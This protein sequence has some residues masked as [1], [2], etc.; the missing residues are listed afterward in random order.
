MNIVI[1]DKNTANAHRRT[2]CTHIPAIGSSY[3]SA[4]YMPCPKVIDV[5][6]YPDNDTL[7]TLGVLDFDISAIIIIQ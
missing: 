7:Q 2:K 4:G 3:G 5:I 1:I 6:S